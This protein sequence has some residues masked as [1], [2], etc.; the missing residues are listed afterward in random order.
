MT[1]LLSLVCPRRAHR[2]S[3]YCK[4]CVEATIFGGLSHELL[5]YPTDFLVWLLARVKTALPNHAGTKMTQKEKGKVDVKFK[6]ERK[7]VAKSKTFFI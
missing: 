6:K 4:T 7:N 1:I 2:F 3:C 5:L